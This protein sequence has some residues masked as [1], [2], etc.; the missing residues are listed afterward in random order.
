MTKTMSLKIDENMFLD[1]KRISEIFNISSSEF[2]RNAIKNELKNRQN[3]FMIRLKN[4]PFCEEKEEK[5]LI[6]VLDSLSD[7]DLQV[8]KK[9]TINL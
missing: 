9:Q 6:N 3:D 8:V 7:D 1:I 2:I 4:V 5:E